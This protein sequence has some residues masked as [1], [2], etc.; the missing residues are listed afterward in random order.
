M[1]ETNAKKEPLTILVVGGHPADVFDNAG[2][3]CYHHSLD[4]D[5]VVGLVLTHGARIH[6]V[7][8]SDEMRKSEEVPQGEK[9]EKLM[10]E[11]AKVKRQEVRNACAIMG[12][13]E[14]R[15]IDMDDEI[16]MLN[17]DLVRAIARIIRDVRP[18]III[19]HYP[20]D[21]GGFADQ[22]AITGQAVLHA[23]WVANTVD[24]GDKKPPFCAAQIYFMGFPSSFHGGGALYTEFSRNCTVYVDVSDVIHLKVKALDCMTSQQYDGRSAV[25][26]IE[27][28][29]GSAGMAVQVP[30][31]E[32]FI[33]AYPEVYRKL[34]LSEFRR[35]TADQ[36]EAHRKDTVEFLYSQDNTFEEYKEKRRNLS[37]RRESEDPAAWEVMAAK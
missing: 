33:V 32:P 16:V 20:Y 22:H 31:A 5:R 11:R 35:R 23:S 30:Y 19:T 4:G 14:V 9:L 26:R 29:E 36:S 13:N 1:S 17:P 6:D 12:I 28:V 18:D 15:F 27:T 24:P 25:K 10:E 8:I 3:T 34:P 21:N 2:G 7:V 37:G